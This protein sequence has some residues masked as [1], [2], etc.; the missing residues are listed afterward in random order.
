MPSTKVDFSY[1]QQLHRVTNFGKPTKPQ[2]HVL[3]KIML[4]TISEEVSPRT[5]DTPLNLN[6]QFRY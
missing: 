5:L 1:N 3:F 4:V 6:K 2:V